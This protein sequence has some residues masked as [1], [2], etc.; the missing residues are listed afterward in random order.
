MFIQGVNH[1]PF[2]DALPRQPYR[3]W[4]LITEK[5]R[6]YKTGGGQVKL[7]LKK[8]KGGGGAEKVFSH[9]EGWGKVLM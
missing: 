9:D 5:G 3:E 7:P 4:S 6:G 8:K 2:C 1:C